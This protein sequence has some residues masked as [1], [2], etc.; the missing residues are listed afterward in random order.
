[1]EKLKRTV[2]FWTLVVAFLVIAPLVVLR[3][4]G[5]RF[6]SSRGVFVHSGSITVK[7]NPLSVDVSLDGKTT[8]S[9]SLSRINNSYTL[10][11]LIPK[12]YELT[13]SAQ[14]FQPWSKKID[15][16][17]GLSSEFWNVI[18]VRD[19]YE[20]TSYDSAGTEKFFISPNDKFAALEQI[21]G[22]ETEVKILNLR[23]D[24]IE[25]SFVL[26]EWKPVSDTA[27]ENIEWS[28]EEDHLSV[29][30]ERTV[31]SSLALGEEK[32]ERA[33]FILDPSTN[34]YFDLNEFLKIPDIRRVRW[35]PQEKGFLFFLSGKLLYRASIS[36]AGALTLI[37]SDVSSYELSESVLH[38]SQSPS[39]LIYR[40][41]LDGT[42]EK[43]QLTNF[44]PEDHPS[45][46]DKLIV[47]DDSKIAFLNSAGELFIY[48][49]GERDTYFR[50]LS[51][52]T[53]GMQ[54]SNDGKKMLFWTKNEISVYFLRDWAVQPARSED[55]VQNITRYSEKLE[56][57]H[58]FKDY[59]HIIFSVGPE[60]KIIELDARDRRNSTDIT[61]LSENDPVVI[62]NNSL[63][64]LFFT[65]S[66]DGTTKLHSIAFPEKTGILGF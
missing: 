56:N 63:E 24:S 54:F 15:V 55:D 62:Y 46:N 38:Y 11:G 35:D 51:D 40:T 4:R 42:A 66:A 39:Q 22:Q 50:K 1:M 47:Y 20:K 57:V 36:S 7:S 58:W 25:N 19:S 10:T 8:E 3:A 18:L 64:K 31:T 60:I 65:D 14:G 27:K 16:H 44:F 12:D 9:K 5:Y 13:V 28:P 49:K 61:K 41:S 34:E 43:T 53:E 48:N 52:S 30:V 23:G 26:P 17:S 37:A 59:E 29:P 32:T 21:S 33:Y 2:F 6:D 45:E